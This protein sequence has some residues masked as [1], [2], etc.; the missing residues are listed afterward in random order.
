M[1][2]AASSARALTPAVDPINIDTGRQ[3]FV[4]DLLIAQTD[5][6]RVWHSAELVDNN[7]ILK[8]ETP[9]ELNAKRGKDAIPVAAP[10]D[11]GVWFDP[12]DGVF[13][14]WYH[15]GWFD[16]LAYATS[17]DGLHWDRPA[18]DVVPGTNRVLPV[19]TVDGHRL[20]RDAASIWLDYTAKDPAQRWKMFTYF[21]QEG[22]HT[23]ES[24]HG[25]LFTSPDGIHFSELH[26]IGYRLG[27]NSSIFY[28]PFRKQWVFSIRGSAPSLRGPGEGKVRARSYYARPDFAK[29]A[30]RKPDE[31]FPLWLSLDARDQRD[32]DLGYEPQLYDFTA[33]AYE[34]LMV[35]VYGV[36][37]GPPNDVCFKEKRPKIIDL[38]LGF[39]RDGYIYDRPKRHAF[40]Q[41]ARTPGAWNCG[42]LHPATGVCLIVGDKLHFYFGAWSGAW[43]GRPGM[44][45]GGSTGLAT[46]RRD[47][48]ASMDADEKPGTLLTVPVQFKGQF[49]FVNASA[50]DGELR[51]EIV[52]AQ[53]QVIAPFSFENSQPMRTDSTKHRL[54]WKGAEDLSSLAGKPVR[55]R[56]RLRQGSL[57]AFWATSDPNGAS[58]G[59][60]AAG[61]P[62]YGGPTDK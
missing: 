44:Y 22:V 49:A 43:D 24:E 25:Q 33:V 4:D 38:Q 13:K 55:F 28:D 46:L 9:L 37:Y 14:M 26:S 17:K 39:S 15:A 50:K 48:F 5:L 34:S 35:G 45:A 29:L 40:I 30:E 31:R 41:S 11:D 52:D 61:G 57:Y 20:M 21:R 10:F 7:P 12:A 27:D 59:Y 16:G 60:V 18:L 53:G 23:P 6:K 8:P 54:A 47:G 56:F 51:A 32:F 42:Y 62:G 58:H 3:L 36:F 1:A 2:F 19:M